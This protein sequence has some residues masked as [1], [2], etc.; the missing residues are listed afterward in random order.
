M[1]RKKAILEKT[2]F[3]LRQDCLEDAI[4]YNEVFSQDVKHSS[5]CILLALIA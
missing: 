3:D 5:I 2:T 1:P 4:N